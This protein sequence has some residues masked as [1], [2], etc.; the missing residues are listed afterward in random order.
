MLVLI[1]QSQRG[2]IWF[3][4]GVILGIIATI[5]RNHGV[6]GAG[7]AFLATVLLVCT[8][9]KLRQ[10]LGLAFLFLNGIVIGYLPNILLMLGSAGFFEAFVYSIK[11]IVA[12][13]ST[14]IALPVPWPWATKFSGEGLVFGGFKLAASLGFL[15]V[16]S[17]PAVG[18]VSLAMRRF[19]LPDNRAVVMAATFLAALPYAQYALSR[20][21]ITHLAG[22][23]FPALIGLSVVFFNSS[24]YGIVLQ[25]VL[26]VFSMAAVAGFSMFMESVLIKPKCKF[27]SVDRVQICAPQSAIAKLEAVDRILQNYPAAKNKFLALPNMPLIHAIYGLKIPIWEIYTLIPRGEA[28]ELLEI[29]RLASAKPGLIFISDAALDGREGLRYSRLHPLVFAWI[30]THYRKVDGAPTTAIEKFDVYEWAGPTGGS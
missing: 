4:A 17:F 2:I 10:F 23:M 11:Q 24:R 12:Y 26:A 14:N 3:F 13:G 16:V 9:G 22:G 1:L 30:A 21:D 15:L 18:G 8:I 28:F 27:I 5:G 19:I 20:A 6:Y 29:E 25:G 7:A